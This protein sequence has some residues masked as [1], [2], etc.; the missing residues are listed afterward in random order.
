MQAVNPTASKEEVPS[1]MESLKSSLTL[2]RTPDMM[3][4]SFTLFYTGLHLTLWDG[5]FSTCIGFTGGYNLTSLLINF[6]KKKTP[7]TIK[8]AD[9][10]S[11]TCMYV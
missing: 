6:W 4:F 10:V 5:L 11:L 8:I 1:V 7:M 3:A 9:N 2:L